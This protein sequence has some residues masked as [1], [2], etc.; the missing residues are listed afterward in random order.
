MNNVNSVCVTVHTT[1]TWS[2]ELVRITKFVSKHHG[3]GHFKP[4]Q[5][6]LP[7]HS[8][9]T[10]TSRSIAGTWDYSADLLPLKIWV[11][12]QGHPGST[13]IS[14]VGFPIYDFLLMFNSNIWSKPHTFQD[15]CIEILSDPEFDPSRSAHL[16]DI[17][18]DNGNHFSLSPF[19]VT[20][21]QTWWYHW[22]PQT[23]FS[24]SN[25]WP[26]KS[27]W[28]RIWPF[29]TA[30]VDCNDA[31]GFSIYYFGLMFNSNIWTTCT[32]AL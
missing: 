26:P 10:E 1:W 16:R 22:N 14:T 11:A 7:K 28:P 18:L 4:Y 6:K 31:I 2:I 23:W 13:L 9:I 15:T 27:E 5:N 12:I 21:G 19:M 30:Q 25:I 29:K 24:N 20:Q 3:T 8:V 17:I 32:S